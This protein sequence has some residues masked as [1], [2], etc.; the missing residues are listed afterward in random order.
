M[1]R[2]KWLEAALVV[3]ALSLSVAWFLQA[4]K[5]FWDFT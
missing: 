2:N 5:I 4:L 3:T 1:T